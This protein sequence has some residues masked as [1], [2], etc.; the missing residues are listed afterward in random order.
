MPNR[1]PNT[2]QGQ[3]PGA[4]IDNPL[5]LFDEDREVELGLR[6]PVKRHSRKTPNEIRLPDLSVKITARA[7][8]TAQ[9]H[10]AETETVSFLDS[11]KRMIARL[12][13]KEQSVLKTTASQTARS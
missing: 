4:V 3:N 8:E 10:M 1:Q 5:G 13:G 12:R 2:S 9:K 6:E 7:S 11:V